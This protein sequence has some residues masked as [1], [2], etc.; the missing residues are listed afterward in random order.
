MKKHN[1]IIREIFHLFI[2]YKIV[3]IILSIIILYLT[4]KFFP[5]PF[6]F[7]INLIQQFIK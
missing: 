6:N 2:G 3:E 7:Y 1:S 4:Y 5:K